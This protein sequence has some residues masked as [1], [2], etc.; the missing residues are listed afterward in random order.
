[1][2]H[3]VSPAIAVQLHAN[4]YPQPEPKFG[5]FWHNYESDTK[6][7]LMTR[8][9]ILEEYGFYCRD[10]HSGGHN[11]VWIAKERFGKDLIYLPTATEIM[12]VLDIQ[13]VGLYYDGKKWRLGDPEKEFLY[14]NPADAVAMSW[15][16]R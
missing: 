16:Y 14:E 9:S 5:Q 6:Y 7:E 1:M 12:E 3:R 4:G 15:L 13:V 8:Y 2:T 10:N 11:I